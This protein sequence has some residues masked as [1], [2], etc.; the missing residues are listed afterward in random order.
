MPLT[1]LLLLSH[2]QL[3]VRFLFPVLPLFNVAAS[4]AAARLWQNRHKSLRWRV[5][6]G[7]TAA[8]LAGSVLA[9]S[10]MLYISAYNY[11]GAAGLRHLLCKVAYALPAASSSAS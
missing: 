1:H 7:C 8:A 5:A 2:S 11:P 3:Q 9:S 6:G 4:T 10:F